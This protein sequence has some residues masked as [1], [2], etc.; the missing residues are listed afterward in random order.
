MLVVSSNKM[1]QNK[2]EGFD[3]LC[4]SVGLALLMGQKVQFAL[5]Y[6]FGVYRLVRNSWE[7]A[8]SDKKVK[9]YLSK[10]M[11]VVVKDIKKNAP[12]PDDLA[13]KVDQFKNDRN[14]LVHDFD[15]ES[16]PYIVVG[17]RI[18]HYIGKMEKIIK[19][20]QQIMLDLDEIGDYLMRE[21][22]I[23]PDKVEQVASERIKEQTS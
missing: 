19:D 15:E 4:Y 10:P 2:P 21:K 11:G 1:I 16:T 3:E 14:W 17:Q 5:A 9:Y 20:A 23:S 7:K 8:K 12:L 13:L 18:E 6:Y 22:G